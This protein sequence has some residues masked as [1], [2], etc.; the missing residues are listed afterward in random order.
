MTCVFNQLMDADL[1]R[2]ADDSLPVHPVTQ[3][4]YMPQIDMPVDEHP[5]DMEFIY[6]SLGS[7]KGRF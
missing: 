7:P 3:A 6:K 5:R 4:F 1:P 2:A